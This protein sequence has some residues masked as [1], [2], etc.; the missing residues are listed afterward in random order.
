MAV[1]SIDQ[2]SGALTV[3]EQAPTGE[4]PR[5]F[6]L[7]PGGEEFLVS[8]GQGDGTLTVYRRDAETGKLSEVQKITGGGG[9]GWVL[10]LELP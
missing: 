1:F 2:S 9:P 4:T 6:N 7:I 8:A 10:G 5:S 3:V